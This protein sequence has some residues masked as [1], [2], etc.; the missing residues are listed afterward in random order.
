MGYAEALDVQV[1]LAHFWRSPEGLQ[2]AQLFAKQTWSVGDHERLASAM[3]RELAAELMEA[4]TYFVAAPIAAIL[5]TSIDTLPDGCL[6]ENSISDACGLAV[7]EEPVVFPEMDR[8]DDVKSLSAILWKRGEW[9]NPRDP[10]RRVTGVIFSYFH[11][12]PSWGTPVLRGRAYWPFGEEW[13]WTRIG[14]ARGGSETTRRM[15]ETQ[16]AYTF[17]F[18]N[19]IAQPICAVANYPLLNRS[20]RRRIARVLDREPVVKVVELRRR[21]YQ[22]RDESRERDVEYTCQ[23]FVRGH[24]RN[25]FFPASGER[26]PLWIAPHVKGPADKP[27]KVPRATAYE[28]VR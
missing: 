20:A 9:P 17:A 4:T 13:R 27:L 18:L 7:F 11:E 21:E 8:E 26:R 10:R 2:L 16:R 25:H 12:E 6:A 1:R 23:W 5:G 22:R 19:F 3:R 15:T 28:V 24:W 14:D